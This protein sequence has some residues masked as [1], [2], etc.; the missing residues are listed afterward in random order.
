MNPAQL[1]RRC[2]LTRL[3]P[4]T[5]NGITGKQVHDRGNT[6]WMLGVLPLHIEA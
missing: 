5:G 2:R 6:A 4:D 1:I 3:D